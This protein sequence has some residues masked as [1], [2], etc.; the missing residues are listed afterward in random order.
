MTSQEV[1]FARCFFLN[2][3]E[4]LDVFKKWRSEVISLTS[5]CAKFLDNFI[6]GV[7]QKTL[8]AVRILIS[9]CG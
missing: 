5:V 9:V 7:V 3:T 1:R 8:I 2:L 4:G 6:E